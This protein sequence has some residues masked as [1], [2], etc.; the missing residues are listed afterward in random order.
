MS[1]FREGSWCAGMNLKVTYDVTSD[2]FGTCAA[3]VLGKKYIFFILQLLFLYPV[4]TFITSNIYL[5][6]KSYYETTSSFQFPGFRPQLGTLNSFERPVCHP[7]AFTLLDQRFPNVWA[8][9]TP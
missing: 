8:T 1:D 7:E 5:P 6:V 2:F 3:L 9:R 4:L